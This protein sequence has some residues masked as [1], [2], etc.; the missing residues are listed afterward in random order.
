MPLADFTKR[1]LALAAK[2]KPRRLRPGTGY[3]E[4]LPGVHAMFKAGFAA[5]DIS[6]EIARDPKWGD[7]EKNSALYRWVARQKPAATAT[8][9]DATASS[10]S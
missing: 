7:G 9:A 4:L 3:A 10:Q 1:A 8:K 6:R 5:L 2:G